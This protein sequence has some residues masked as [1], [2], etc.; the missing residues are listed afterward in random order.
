LQ[1]W[2]PCDENLLGSLTWNE[3]MI[4]KSKDLGCVC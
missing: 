2:C 4:A 3:T 1:D